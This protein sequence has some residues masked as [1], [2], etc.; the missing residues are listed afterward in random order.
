M[1]AMVDRIPDESVG[2]R[3]GLEIRVGDLVR[4]VTRSGEVIEGAFHYGWVLARGGFALG[5]K[6]GKEARLRRVTT[7]HPVVVLGPGPS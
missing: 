4:V 1:G 3:D 7:L 2:A 5:I 6:P